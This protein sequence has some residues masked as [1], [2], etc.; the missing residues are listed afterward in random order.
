MRDVVV[1]L[2]DFTVRDA[3]AI[4]A[5]LRSRPMSKPMGGMKMGTAKPKMAMKADLNDVTYD[6]FLA[7]RRSLS[8]PEIFPVTRSVLGW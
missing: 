8:D 3:A 1:M 2:N 6:A 7:N 4:L 5:G